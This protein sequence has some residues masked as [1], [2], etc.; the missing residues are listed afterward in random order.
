VVAPGKAS[1]PVTVG[2]VDQGL[3]VDL[4]GGTISNL[5]TSFSELNQ[6]VRAGKADA[7]RTVASTNA[8]LLDLASRIKI[9]HRAVGQAMSHA[10]EAGSLLI[11]AKK[12]I[13]HGVW[14]PWVEASCEMSLRVAQGYMRIARHL[15]HLDQENAK[16]VS[17]LSIRDA[18]KMF[19]RTATTA[20][21]LPAAEFEE[22]LREAETTS[23]TAIISDVAR[24]RTNER[25]FAAKP[26]RTAEVASQEAQRASYVPLAPHPPCAVE[27]HVALLQSLLAVVN[28]Y[29]AEK[30]IDDSDVL[31]IVNELYGRLGDGRD[32]VFLS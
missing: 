8:C 12:K 25:K 14:V 16:R 24:R 30:E 2:T 10:I 5:A 27:R 28:A 26:A 15:G 17:R 4:L 21:A 11:E 1:A 9:A 7:M 3:D 20:K 32:Q 19:S 29:R 6:D 23:P 18:L 13:P 22:V 31:T